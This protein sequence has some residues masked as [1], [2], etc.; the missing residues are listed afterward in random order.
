MSADTCSRTVRIITSLIYFMLPNERIKFDLP[1]LPPDLPPP[2]VEQTARLI[3]ASRLLAELKGLLRTLPNPN[4]LLQPI[5]LQE[6][7][8]SSEIENIVTTHDEL[9][10]ALATPARRIRLASRPAAA[11]PP[12][13]RQ[14]SRRRL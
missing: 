14:H 2:D 8:A 12:A 5:L 10:T 13:S 4:L 7:R 11:M 6:A 1:T 3:K 9:Y